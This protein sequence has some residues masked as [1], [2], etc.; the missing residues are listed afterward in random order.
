MEQL[1]YMSVTMYGINLHPLL[2]LLACRKLR[3]ST[4]HVLTCITVQHIYGDLEI[5]IPMAMMK[6]QEISGKPPFSNHA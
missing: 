3:D 5:F 6:T 1:F 2:P 4:E